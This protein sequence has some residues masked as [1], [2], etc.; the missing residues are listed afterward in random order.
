VSVRPPIATGPRTP[1]FYYSAGDSSGTT[2]SIGARNGD[3]AWV[4]GW[5]GK[6]VK[7]PTDRGRHWQ[8]AVVPTRDVLAV[9]PLDRIIQ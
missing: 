3:M 6:L 4:W 5:G 9:T 8:D 1:I 7:I 2:D